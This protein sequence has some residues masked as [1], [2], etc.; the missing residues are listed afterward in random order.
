VSPQEFCGFL[1]NPLEGD[2]NDREK[3]IFM[4]RV[5][6]TSFMGVINID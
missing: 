2:G 6:S 3:T 5:G 1:L 4:F